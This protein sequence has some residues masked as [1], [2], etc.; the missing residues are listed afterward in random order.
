ME[1]TA[2]DVVVE[3]LAVMEEIDLVVVA[4]DLVVVEE[5]SEEE[6]EID[7]EA[8]A[9]DLEVV[10]EV[11]EVDLEVEAE[12]VE[13]GDMTTNLNSIVCIQYICHKNNKDKDKRQ[14]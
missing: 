12:V 14:T 3:D 10:I 11:T 6:E 9:I 13:E 4:I 7:L 8:V 2:E 1:D 5:D